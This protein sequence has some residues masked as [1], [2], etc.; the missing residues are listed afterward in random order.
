M[1]LSTI[2]ALEP[3]LT[4]VPLLVRASL[5][6]PLSADGTVRNRFRV[7][8]ALTTLRELS[9]RGAKVTLIAHI[10]RDPEETLRPVFDALAPDLPLRW[11]GS[12]TDPGFAAAHASLV[13]GDIDGRDLRRSR[14]TKRSR[15]CRAPRAVG[16]YFG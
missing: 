16:A 6:V 2:S 9:E 14:E 1:Q 7:E 4:D 15:V 8:R 11:G 10:G 5:N 13:Q 3:D 12:I